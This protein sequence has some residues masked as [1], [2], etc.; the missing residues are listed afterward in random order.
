MHVPVTNAHAY[1]YLCT[2]AGLPGDRPAQRRLGHLL[3]ATARGGA[4]GAAPLRE[5]IALSPTLTLTLNLTLTLTLNLTPTPTLTSNPNPNPNPDPDPNPNPNPNQALPAAR[6]PRLRAF[7]AAIPDAG[8]RA[9][10]VVL[11]VVAVVVVV[12]VVVVVTVV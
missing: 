12:V 8:V 7:I 11:A 10:G 4:R 2:H 5:G 6:T 9:L 3:G 1:A